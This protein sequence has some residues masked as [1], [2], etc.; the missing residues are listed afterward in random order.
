M[1]FRADLHCHSTCSDGTLTVEE[2]L[3]LA[4]KNGIQGLSI[5]DHDTLGAYPEALILGKKLEIQVIPGV[6]FSTHFKGKSVHILGYSFDFKSPSLHHLCERHQLRREERNR[7]ILEKLKTKNITIQ[8][9]EL[10]SSSLL[11]TIGRPHIAKL[12]VEK[13]VVPDI[14]TAFHR[15]IGDGK[16]CYVQGTTFTIEE[17]LDAIHQA[18]GLAVLAHPHLQNSRSFV[19]DILQLPFDGLECEYA[20]MPPQK[21]APWIALALEKKLLMTGGSDFHG[22]VKPNLK[23]GATAVDQ[24]KF[25]PLLEQF[26]SHYEL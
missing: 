24:E 23:L 4:K 20:K 17:T 8:P 13:G 2:L 21:N 25:S 22:S 12:L 18:K 26:H 11:H 9:E 1:T 3:Q 19:A 16:S 10:A 5:T 14:A 6:E 15:Y 7:L